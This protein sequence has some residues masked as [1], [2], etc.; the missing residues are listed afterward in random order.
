MLDTTFTATLTTFRQQYL[1]PLPKLEKSNNYRHFKPSG[2]H[3][4]SSPTHFFLVV[5]TL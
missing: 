2:A 3:Y 5:P 1:T 4:L